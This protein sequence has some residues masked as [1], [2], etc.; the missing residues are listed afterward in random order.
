MCFKWAVTSAMF[1]RK[2]HPER[3]NDEMH[4]NAKKLDWSGI[5]FPT[6]LNQIARFERQNSCAINVYGCDNNMNIY[7]LKCTKQDINKN[8]NISLLLISDDNTNHYCWIKDMSRLLSSQI[9]NHQHK[10]FFCHRC[11]NSFATEDSLEQHSEYC[12]KHDAVKIVM[13]Q[14]DKDGKPP[15]IVFKN[16]NRK[17]KVP[18]IIYADFEC[19]TEKVAGCNPNDNESFTN[20]YQ[21]HK[22]SG[23]SYIIKCFDDSVYKPKLVS[24]TAQSPDEDIPKVFVDSLEADIKDLY[25]RFKFSKKMF[26]TPNDHIAHNNA[27]HCH[28]CEEV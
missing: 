14:K 7:P 24:H 6:P 11:L 10:R 19:F 2:V 4:I 17:M 1:P 22:P 28:I 9:N 27:T 16:H 12:S 15:N 26:M 20:K 5:E 23:F 25:N 21:K 18:F 3:L 8:T 13:P